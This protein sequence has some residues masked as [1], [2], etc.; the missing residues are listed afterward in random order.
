MHTV[1]GDWGRGAVTELGA[2]VVSWSPAGFEEQLFLARDAAL[3][4]G[5]M[6][7]GGV[8][9][10]APWFGSGTG[11]WTVPH[12]HGLVSRVPWRVLSLRE[13]DD[14]ARFELAVSA[15]ETAHLAGADRYPD[16]LAYSLSVEM[17]RRLRL[18]LTIAS[19]SRQ[20]TVDQAFHPYLAVQANQAQLT[21]L[22]GLRFRDYAADGGPTSQSSPV[23][24]GRYVDRVYDGAPTTLLSDGSR[25]LAMSGTGAGSVVVWNP[26]PGGDQVGDEWA[27]FACVEYGNVQNRAVVIP[28]AGT[29]TLALTITPG[30]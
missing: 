2:C 19:P 14:C 11:E 7:H 17:G 18:A 25:S 15:A 28:A 6:W 9:I 5:E 21:G 30:R 24:F 8:P 20:V 22:E 26:G 29:H 10:C 13:D 3:V 4:P 23:R 16:D 12:I 1:K 27:S